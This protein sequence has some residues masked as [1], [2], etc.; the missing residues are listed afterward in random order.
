MYIVQYGPNMR[1]LVASLYY[2]LNGGLFTFFFMNLEEILTFVF[3]HYVLL[4]AY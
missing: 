2:E 4:S 3:V 1:R